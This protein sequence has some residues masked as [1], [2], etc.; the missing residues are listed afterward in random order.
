[1]RLP[2]AIGAAVLVIGM[3]A[4]AAAPGPLQGEQGS[5]LARAIQ[6]AQRRAADLA[7]EEADIVAQIAGLDDLQDEARAERIQRLVERK[8]QMEAEVADLE[9]ELDSTSAE[10]RHDE[11][12]ATR[13]LHEAAN[14]IR[15]NKLKE[16]IR[17]S[18]GLTRARSGEYA[19]QFEEE[20][21]DDIGD[22]I[23]GVANAAEALSN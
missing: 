5:R 3:T 18:R 19:L 16:K 17:Y 20:I 12:D 9:R 1:M 14:G 13:E 4:S 10:F 6:E 7:A 2:T 23:Q 15:T 11:P 8:N 22:L 21:S